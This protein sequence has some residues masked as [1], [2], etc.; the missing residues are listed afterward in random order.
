MYFTNRYT[1]TASNEVF[2][3]GYTSTNALGPAVEI[4]Q[5]PLQAVP[6]GGWGGGLGGFGV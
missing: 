5:M 3:I 2:T 6:E 4:T 1:L